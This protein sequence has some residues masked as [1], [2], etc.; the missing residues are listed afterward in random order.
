MPTIVNNFCI[1]HAENPCAARIFSLTWCCEAAKQRSSE[2]A[3]QRSSEAA[4]Q[5]SS[6]AA[7]QHRSTAAPQHRSTAAPQHRS[8]APLSFS[9]NP[10]AAR[11]KRGIFYGFPNA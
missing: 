3:K 11:R 8:T 10:T 9:K 5:R 2:A 4:P 6:T 1:K 7:P